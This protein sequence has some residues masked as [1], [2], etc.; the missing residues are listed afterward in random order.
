MITEQCDRR[1]SFRAFVNAAEKGASIPPIAEDDLK[2]LHAISVDMAKRHVGKNGVVGVEQMARVCSRGANLPA[3]WFRYTRLRLL[4]RQGILAE[5]QHNTEF[6]DAVY[7]VA[8]TIPMNG[9]ELDREAFVQ[10]LRCET[11]A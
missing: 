11:P 2:R 5:W 4:A 9:F 3:G 7:R 6:D 1:E 10:R 8:A